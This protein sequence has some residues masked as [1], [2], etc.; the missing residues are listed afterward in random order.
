M[1]RIDHRFLRGKGFRRHDEQ[2]R[3]RIQRFQRFL[4]MRA[5]DVGNEVHLQLWMVV[6]LQCLTHHPRPQIR[7]ADTDVHTVADTLAGKAAPTHPCEPARQTPPYV[8]SPRSPSA[9]HPRR[10]HESAG[11]C[12]CA[13]THASTQR[14]SV[15]LIFSP[16]NMH[17]RQP[18][19]PPLRPAA[20][21]KAHGVASD[22]ILRI[23]RSTRPPQRK[24]L[25]ARRWPH[26]DR[27]YALFPSVRDAPATHDIQAG[28]IHP[29]RPPR[30]APSERLKTCCPF[31]LR[32][33]QRSSSNACAIAP[34]VTSVT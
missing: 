14:F 1:V 19:H 29:A 21:S 18:A 25:E 7:A 17:S 31:C 23:V 22:A 30:S 20:S 26:T 10:R 6:R 34:E 13:A 5:V 24:P 11:C 15:L 9:S 12:D 28:A 2:R 16:V 8:R 32:D 4:Y 33:F 3:L 27:D